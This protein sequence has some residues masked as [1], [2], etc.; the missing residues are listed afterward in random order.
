M[1]TI[2]EKIL[3]ALAALATA[4]AGWRAIDRLVKIIARGHGKPDWNLVRRRLFSALGKTISLAPTW[5]LRPI[6]TVLHALVAW[7][8][9]YYLLVNFGDVW[10]G[11]FGGKFLGHNALGNLY[12]LGADVLTVAGITGMLALMLRRAFKTA[13]VPPGGPVYLAMAHHAR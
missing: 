13:A 2:I 5:R 7:S 1:L 12:R 8:F 3:F 6:P 11:Y 10:E 9:M 4:Y